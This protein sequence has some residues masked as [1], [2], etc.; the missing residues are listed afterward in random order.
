MKKNV[1]LPTAA[2]A[3]VLASVL[4]FQITYVTLKGNEQDEKSSD[5][6]QNSF[7]ERATEKLTE[8]DERFRKLYIGDL[9]DDTLVDYVMKGYMAGTG[10]AYGAYYTADEYEQ[11]MKDLNADSE[12][13]G[14]SV[15]FNSELRCI[16]IID[17][18]PSS[19]A[20]EAGVEVGDLVAYIGEEKESVSSL[21]YEAA[22]S[23]LRGEAGT[24]AVFSVIRGENAELIEFSVTREHVESIS[25]MSHVYSPDN[26]IGVIKITGFDKKTPEQFKSAIEGLAEEGC[27]KFIF[28]LRY[29]PGGEL[30]SVV[31]T[32]DYLLPEGPVIR[33]FDAQ[34]NLVGQE[35]SDEECVD[36]PFAIVVNGSTASAAELFTSAMMDYDRATVVGTTTYGK[37]CMQTHQL[38]SDGSALSV[39]Y[40]MYK[41]PFS[42]GYHSVGIKPD[43]EVELDESLKGISIYKITDEMDN[44]LAEAAN[45]LS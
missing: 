34:D 13:I 30:T 19:P 23:K 26:S 40:R 5:V 25:V 27:D 3:A 8:L 45:V 24:D 41:P 14:V 9:D 6:S 39:T 37:G 7:I 29:N 44:Q 21:G 10:D 28:D 20:F 1:S 32:L 33:I 31:S 35:S 17:V 43:I 12:G 36:Y 42:E 11:Q 22:L 4:T 2:T 15:I 18:L 16:E 38:L